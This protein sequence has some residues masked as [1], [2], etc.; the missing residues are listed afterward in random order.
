MSKTVKIAYLAPEIPALSATFVYNEI[1]ALETQGY[2][3]FPVSVHIPKN[4]AREKEIERLSLKTWYLYKE[5]FSEFLFANWIVFFSHPVRY[6]KTSLTA[7]SDSLKT[8]F[9]SRVGLGL[10]YRFFVASRIAIVLKKRKI[11][12]LHTHFSHVPTDIAMYASALSGIPFTF[13]SHANDL[14]ERG[15]LL[16]EKVFRSKKAITISEF[17]KRFLKGK[18]ADESKIEI[19]RCGVRS[20]EY[21]K[22]IPADFSNNRPVRIGTLGRL[23]EKKGIDSLIKALSDFRNIEKDFL[24]EIAGDGP[25]MEELKNLVVEQKLQT[26][27]AFIGAIPHNEVNQWLKTLDLFIL[28]CKKDKNGD[29]DGI[30][31]VLMEAM[32]MGI[33][34]ISTDI[35][36]IPELIKDGISGFLAKADDPLSLSEKIDSVY[37]TLPGPPDV[38]ENGLLHIKEEFDIDLNI[39][40]LVSIF[41]G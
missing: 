10:L 4:A 12:H 22:V 11:D 8:G 41:K 40:R 23:V 17:N 26:K 21:K 24:L 28:S 33:P 14:F 3:I 19:V 6:I 37:R 1:L 35:S 13:T 31:V 2:D 5:S 7:I 29:Q 27:T 32:A 15:W 36:G 20:G 16:K 9:M 39:K 25:L 18:G 38:T 30:P 34:V